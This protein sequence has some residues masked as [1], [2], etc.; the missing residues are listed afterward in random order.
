MRNNL[1]IDNNK[2]TI[3][4]V[5]DFNRLNEATIIYGKRSLEILS[6][7]NDKVHII[8]GDDYGWINFWNVKKINE[9]KFDIELNNSFS[10]HY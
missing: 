2:L 6:E 10:A 8:T 1:T 4:S 3:W 7:S 5:P 9:N